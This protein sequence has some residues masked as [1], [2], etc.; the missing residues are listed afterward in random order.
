MSK[1]DKSIEKR[2][3]RSDVERFL[4]ELAATPTTGRTGDRGRLIF[5]LDATASREPT[6]DRACH[7]QAEMFKETA[8]LGGLEIQLV[9]YRGFLELEASPWCRESQELLQRMTRVYC[10]AGQTQIGRV[11]DHALAETRRKRVN[12]LVLAGDCM[13]EDPDHLAGLAG[14]LGLL[15]VPA[16]LFH[17]G[18][19]PVAERSFR[20]IARL[21]GGA[22]C[23]FDAGS[24]RELRDLL[25]AVAVYA[26][27][28]RKALEAHGRRKGGVVLQLTHQLGKKD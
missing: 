21:T 12:A 8:S 18:Y 15:G 9:Y 19:D 16:F 14:E 24:A 4:D 6:W 28:G 26:A 10:A 20:D 2:S 11:L 27:G 17:E 22:Y 7:I 3:S 13:E 5:A 25:A 23:R 1:D